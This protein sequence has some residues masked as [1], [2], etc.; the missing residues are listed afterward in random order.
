[1][2]DL[3]SNRSGTGTETASHL[4]ALHLDALIVGAGFSGLYML[5]RLRQLG[6]SVRTYEA[7]SEVGGTWFWNRYPGA[8]CDIDSMNYSYSFSHELE[9]EWK[10]T[11]RYATQPEI[12]RYLNHVADRFGLRQDIQ[13][14]TRVASA[15]FDEATN[16]WKIQTDDG[17]SVSARF[18]IMATGCLSAAK[19]PDFKGLETSQARWY[20][21]S[22]WPHEG[23]DF[24][25]QRVGVIG[26]GSSG[27]Q[28][29]PIIAEQADH[30][31]VFQRTPSFS[32][33]ARNA[34]IDPTY[35]SQMKAS[36]A[37]YRRKARETRAGVVMEVNPKSALDASPEEREHAYK[38]RWE[39]G[40]T[41]F[42]ATFSDV[43]RSREA[44]ET[45]A[46]F[47]RSRIRATVRDPAVADAL[48]PK[49]YPLGTK[50]I[51]VDTHYY[52]TFN[53]DNVTLVDVKTSPIEALTPKGLRTR[54]AEYELDS[55]VFATG[56]DAF[57]GALFNIDIRGRGNASLKQKWAEGPRTYLGVAIAG[58]PNLFTI[59]GPGSPSVFGNAIVSIEQHVDWITDCITYLQERRLERIEATAEAE[60]KWVAHVKEVADGTLYPLANS[61]YIG[62]NIPGKPRVL[63]PYAGGVGAY[64]KTCEA[65]AAQHYEGFSLTKAG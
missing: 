12:L 58:F 6:L 3:Q 35:E 43:M 57:T 27:I 39:L 2:S 46:E 54:S 61:W 11:E 19:V 60:D 18:L 50:R 13:F 56:F 1:M 9:Q 30:L 31:F 44:N 25:G 49:D 52:E 48:S 8:R 34:P 21:T 65:V 41:S 29:I 55:I 37:E 53:R 16:R 59:T 63:L 4:D 5:Y 64:R 32:V 42:L 14:R 17:A 45:A 15:V 26:T 22:R 7:G 10:W 38:A 24:T 47:I 51:C 40:G 28:V 62:A 36:Y 33:P 23:V 20:H